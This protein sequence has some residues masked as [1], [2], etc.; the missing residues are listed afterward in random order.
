MKERVGRLRLE[1][2]GLH[3]EIEELRDELRDIRTHLQEDVAIKI[4][5]DVRSLIAQGSLLCVP[6]LT[7]SVYSYFPEL[8][9]W[10]TQ[11]DEWPVHAEYANL[12]SYGYS[13]RR[14]YGSYLFI[15]EF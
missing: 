10:Y 5:W 2:T 14:S 3:D 13:Y 6:T 12:S 11:G 7:D 15:L 9:D 4:D 1:N 8:N